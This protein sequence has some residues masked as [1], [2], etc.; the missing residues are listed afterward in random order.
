VEREVAAEPLDHAPVRQ[1]EGAG[2]QAGGLV[3][4]AT[5]SRSAVKLPPPAAEQI[6]ALRL[7][8]HAEVEYGKGYGGGRRG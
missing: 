5:P 6:S 7:E 4:D 2:D 3:G 1:W 8:R